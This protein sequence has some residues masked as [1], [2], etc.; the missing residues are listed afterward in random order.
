VSQEKTTPRRINKDVVLARVQRLSVFRQGGMFGPAEVVALAG[1][2]L[3]L[4][5][6]L[7]GYFYFQMPSRARLERLQLERSRLQTQLRSSNDLI[8]R[9]ESTETTVQ[10]IAQSLDEFESNKLLGTGPGRMSLYDALNTMIRKNGLRNTSGPTYTPLDPAGT[11]TATGGTKASTKWQSVYPGVAVSVTVEGQY[12]N[13][14]RFVR[15]LE[16]TKQFVIINAIELERSSETNSRAEAEDAAGGAQN[17]IVS[18]R[19]D[20]ATYFQRPNLSVGTSEQ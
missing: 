12:Q 14:R 20:M 1:S 9:G 2:L 16:T 3:I 19:L 10:R 6:V 7:V 8:T 5:L 11:K 15:D 17:S 13:L 4:L 18:L